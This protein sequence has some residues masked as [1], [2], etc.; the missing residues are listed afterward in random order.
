[1]PKM[2]RSRAYIRIERPYT[3]ISKFRKKSFIRITPARK[4]VRFNMGEERKRKYSLD[5]VSKAS[6]QI[7]QEAIESA[8]MTSLR[9]LEKNVPGKFFFR[10]R[11][12]PYH[13][14]RENPLAA[15]AG[16]DRVSTGMKQSFGKPI[17]VALQLKKGEKLFTVTVNEANLEIARKALQ[18]ATKKMPCGFTIKIN[19][20]KPVSKKTESN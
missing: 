5:L 15:G 1:M 13:I 14:L 6:V 17:G 8:R 10:I 4:I 7:R 11:K 16:A 19:K 12:Y 18:R 20:E 3:R 2:R 9:W